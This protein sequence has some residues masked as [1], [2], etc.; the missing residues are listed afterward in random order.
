MIGAGGDGVRAAGGRDPGRRARATSTATASCSSSRAIC[1]PPACVRRL[2]GDADEVAGSGPGPRSPFRRNSR[3]PPGECARGRLRGGGSLSLGLLAAREQSA[4][5]GTAAA[6]WRSAHTSPAAAALSG[7]SRAAR[8]GRSPRMS[9]SGARGLSLRSGRSPRPA[10]GWPSSTLTTARTCS[11]RRERERALPSLRAS[12]SRRTRR[13]TS[14]HGI[15]TRFHPGLER[16]A[17]VSLIPTSARSSSTPRAGLAWVAANIEDDV[18]GNHVI[19]NAR[20]LVLG[21]ARA[22]RREAPRARP[23]AAGAR[24]P[25]QVLPDGGHYERSPAYHLIVLRDL[26]EIR[27]VTGAVWLDEPI[28]RMRGFALGARAAGRR[29]GAL[30]RRGTRPGPETPRCRRPRRVWRYSPTRATPSLR[31]G[32]VWLAFDFGLP[33]PPFLPAHAHADVLSF[34][35][36]VGG[37]PVVVDP[38]TFSYEPGE[39]GTGSA[40]RLRTQ[41]SPSTGGPIRAV[42][43]VPRRWP[44]EATAPFRRPARRRGLRSARH[45]PAQAPA[46]AGAADRRGRARG[47]GHR[48]GSLDPAPCDL[49]APDRADGPLP[50]SRERGWLSERMLER[51]PIELLY[52]SGREALPLTL[53]WRIGLPSSR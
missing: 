2:L 7:M 32:D 33:A 40:R 28:E 42:G 15:R 41:L 52:A 25:G 13:K 39:I 22:R 19:R 21:G 23:C 27:A 31:R 6:G 36:W 14:M 9:S 48:R 26:L 45:P 3:G 46:R 5:A 49:R 24:A 43:G 34:Q 20:A 29:A 8:C 18:L 51:A 4:R 35:L 47:R 30:Q 10:R 17:A 44:A 37:R 50:V 16:V 53:G 12:G 1:R 38:G 11:R